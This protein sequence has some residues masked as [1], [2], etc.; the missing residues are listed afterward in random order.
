MS[1]IFNRP[2][3]SS[4]GLAVTIEIARPDNDPGNYFITMELDFTNN[5][6]E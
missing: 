3:N 6:K 1:N 2:P 5:D 4:E